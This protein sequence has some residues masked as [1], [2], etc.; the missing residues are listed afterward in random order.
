MDRRVKERLIGAT[1]LVAIIVMLVP[2]LLSGPR[3][4][5]APAA[6]PAST[7]EPVRNVTVDLAT[8]KATEVPPAEVDGAA[9]RTATPPLPPEQPVPPAG[10]PPVTHTLSVPLETP[11]SPPK[12]GPAMPRPGAAQDVDPAE[13]ARRG[14]SVQLGSFASRANVDKLAHQ[15]KAQGYSVYVVSTGSGTSMRY[16]VRVGPMPDRGTAERTM[17]KLKAQGHSANIVLPST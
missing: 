10:P 2:E 13:A 12:S 3:P 15:L 7:T 4:K 6:A 1:I 8:S 9:S 11:N 17:A 16:R 5:R 14:W